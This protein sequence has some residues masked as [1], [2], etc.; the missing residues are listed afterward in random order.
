MTLTD[1][2]G[3]LRLIRQWETL[4]ELHSHMSNA[5]LGWPI[6]S[7]LYLP[8]SA[9]VDSICDSGEDG[10]C[11]ATSWA[12]FDCR[13]ECPAG[14]SW[15]RSGF[16][17]AL[18]AFS[19]SASFACCSGWVEGCLRRLLR[20]TFHAS[21]G[22]WSLAPS[23]CRKQQ[24]SPPR[25]PHH[26]QNEEASS[27]QHMTACRS[28]Q[29]HLMLADRFIFYKIPTSTPPR[30]GVLH[31]I[32][33]QPDKGPT[34]TQVLMHIGQPSGPCAGTLAGAAAVPSWACT[35]VVFRSGGFSCMPQRL[36][37]AAHPCWRPPC[38]QAPSLQRVSS[39]AACSPAPGWSPAARR[40]GVGE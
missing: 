27:A 17:R 36:E 15:E 3:G 16:L 37:A 28:H 13:S 6:C 39:S 25:Y 11:T 7:T 12:K 4:F 20:Q 32:R 23:L 30:Q 5:S 35:Q 34:Q 18:Q 40:A 26:L 2:Q 19:C 1:T 9:Q 10:A 14:L 8:H 31:L 21:G 33:W 38:W 22:H 24:L 29:A